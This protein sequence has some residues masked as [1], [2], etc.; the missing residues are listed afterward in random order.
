MTSRPHCKDSE[1]VLKALFKNSDAAGRLCGNV[2]SPR[3]GLRAREQKQQEVGLSCPPEPPAL[4]PSQPVVDSFVLSSRPT[5]LKPSHEF[6]V[7]HVCFCDRRQTHMPNAS[8]H[9]MDTAPKT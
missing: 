8:F 5:L 7:S 1:E 9:S 2:R 4:V 6:A 3:V